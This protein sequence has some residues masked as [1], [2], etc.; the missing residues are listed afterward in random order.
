MGLTGRTDQVNEVA[1]AYA[2]DADEYSLGHTTGVFLLGR[3]SICIGYYRENQLWNTSRVVAD[4]H[5]FLALP[6]GEETAWEPERTRKVQTTSFNG[7][8]LYLENCA[9][10]HQESG[11]GLPDKYP[12]LSHSSWVL[13][14]PNRLVVLTLDGVRDTQTT[15]EKKQAGVMPAYRTGLTPANMAAV[16]TYIRQ[17]WGNNA[18]PI[19]ADYVQKLYSAQP[20]RADFWSWKELEKLPPHTGD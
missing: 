1:K 15:S 9:S 7:R 16:L 20:F 13:G 11:R 14:A 8:Q 12:S 18:S 4:L 2:I 5:R 6:I 19:S 10:C 3:S 17:S